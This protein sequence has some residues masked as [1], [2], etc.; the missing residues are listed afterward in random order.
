MAHLIEA[1]L[2]AGQIDLG[3]RAVDE[4]L[5]LCRTTIDRMYEAEIVRLRG[6]L[7]LRQGDGSRQA[8]EA[9]CTSFE[10]ARALADALGAHTFVLRATT[11]LAVVLRDLGRGAEAAA[12]LDAAIVRFP[13]SALPAVSDPDLELARH[14]RQELP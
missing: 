1:A 2:A 3:L 11:S 6:E 12:A 4:A 5:A 14:L 10:E 13:D 9:A 7:W 8:R